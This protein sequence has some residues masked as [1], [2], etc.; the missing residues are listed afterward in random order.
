MKAVQYAECLP[1]AALERLL[2]EPQREDG[3]A[4]LFH[5]ISDPVVD[6][7]VCANMLM[8]FAIEANW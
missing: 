3:A 8:Q 5:H 7:N 2:F 6:C 1:F 4:G